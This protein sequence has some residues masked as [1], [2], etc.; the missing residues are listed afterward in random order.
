MASLLMAHAGQRSRP[1]VQE[2]A[3]VLGR[4]GL[5]FI[6]CC[7]VCL[8]FVVLGGGEPIAC[9]LLDADPW[10]YAVKAEAFQLE[11]VMFSTLVAVY[12]SG[13]RVRHVESF[14]AYQWLASKRQRERERERDRE[15]ER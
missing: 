15:R 7:W 14:S 1:L 9:R 12:E 3:H 11:T 13:M 2:A 10:L 8:F 4:C 6:V 5:E